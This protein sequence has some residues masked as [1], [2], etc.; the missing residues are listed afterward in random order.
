MPIYYFQMPS[1]REW[2]D[3]AD[4]TRLIRL[5]MRREAA[6]IDARRARVRTLLAAHAA[7]LTATISAPSPYAI[8]RTTNFKS[9]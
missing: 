2:R 7:G 4:F 9:R 8:A 1:S 3:D 5:D 6:S